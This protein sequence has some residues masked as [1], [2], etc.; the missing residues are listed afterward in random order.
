MD[1]PMYNIIVEHRDLGYLN[2]VLR[3]Y[4]RGWVRAST[5]PDPM[6]YNIEI[7]HGCGE[8]YLRDQNH[9]V[10]YSVKRITSLPEHE[11]LRI[12]ERGRARLRQTVTWDNRGFYR[13]DEGGER[14][15]GH[16]VNPSYDIFLLIGDTWTQILADLG[17]E[18]PPRNTVASKR[19]RG[20]HEIYSGTKII[21]RLYTDKPY[22][23]IFGEEAIDN[24]LGMYIGFNHRLLEK[25]LAMVE[26][27][28]EKLGSPDLVIVSFSGG[29]DSIVLLDLALKIYGRNRVVPIYVDTGLEFPHTL[30]YISMVEEYYGLEITRVYAGLDKAVGSKGLPTRDNRWCTGLKQKA[31]YDKLHEIIGGY[32]NVLVLLGDRD[33]ESRSRSHRPP[34]RHREGYLEVSPLKQWGTIHVQTYIL[35]RKLPLNPLY[36]YGFY[37]TGCYIC[38]L[39]RGLEKYIMKRYLWDTL[40]ELRYINEFLGEP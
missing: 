34:V 19:F 38:P 14:I 10:E 23:K 12:I 7:V 3:R 32:D 24:D 5:K 28:L 4:Y 15:H 16:M 40:K 29:K 36:M 31:F 18:N 1:A 17:L 13:L 20:V 11:I 8:G 33:A 6:M 22:L 30:N 37:R 25:H 2:K 39:L 21:A 35:S 27:L 9:V 26:Y